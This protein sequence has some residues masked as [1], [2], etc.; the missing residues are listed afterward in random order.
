[1]PPVDFPSSPVRVFS[2][3]THTH[4]SSLAL[5]VR[6]SVVVQTLRGCCCF[7]TPK[8]PYLPE[9][10]PR[11]T[12]ASRLDCL[13]LLWSFVFLIS[14]CLCMG[15]GVVH[16][17]LWLFLLGSSFFHYCCHCPVWLLSYSRYSCYFSSL[18]SCS[19]SLSLSL[20]G[21][22]QVGVRSV[23]PLLLPCV[24][25]RWVRVLRRTY[26]SGVLLSCLSLRLGACCGA[27]E[28]TN[29]TER[30]TQEACGCLCE[31]RQSATSKHP[32][33]TK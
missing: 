4:T 9:Y 33:T 17:F 32:T 8:H 25:L 7:A 27:C 29:D 14:A 23:A 2:A 18:S 30:K 20:S 11:C 3:H 24:L 10:N 19:L 15:L 5:P 1:M 16:P 21:A 12:Y 26:C 6:A 22:E 28:K 13:S 31:G